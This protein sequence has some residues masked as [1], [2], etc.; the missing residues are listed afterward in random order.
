MDSA[1]EKCSLVVKNINKYNYIYILGLLLAIANILTVFIFKNT[2]IRNTYYLRVLML[3]AVIVFAVAIIV[4]GVLFVIE[5]VK[6]RTNKVIF[7]TRL[8]LLASAF[9]LSLYAIIKYS[10]DNNIYFYHINQTNIIFLCCIFLV[11]CNILLKMS[12]DWKSFICSAVTLLI[13]D[14]VSIALMIVYIRERNV[15]SENIALLIGLISSLQCICLSYNDK[16]RF[17]ITHIGIALATFMFFATLVTTCIS[18]TLFDVLNMVNFLL[19]FASIIM[20][21]SILYRL[22]ENENVVQFIFRILTLALFLT[23][24]IRLATHDNAVLAKLDET[25]LIMFSGFVSVAFTYLKEFKKPLTIGYIAIISVLSVVCLAVFG[26]N[27]AQI[28]LEP[29]YILTLIIVF[30]IISLN[31]VYSKLV[32]RKK[33]VQIEE[34]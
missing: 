17:G 3:V 25:R 31:I 27:R 7:I 15:N 30:V 28:D 5:Y 8:S 11:V 13:V 32:N 12:K 14:I 18:R 21:S 10:L 16:V 29:Y 34:G 19:S 23:S 4:D 33:I 20:I 2:A 6:N 9:A 1:K 22:Q 24:L 26:A